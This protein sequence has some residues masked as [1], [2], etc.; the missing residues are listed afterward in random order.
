LLVDSV[1]DYTSSLCFNSL[2]SQL[3][4]YIS[5]MPD[6][7]GGREVLDPLGGY[8]SDGSDYTADATPNFQ[9][10]VKTEAMETVI[11]AN[12]QGFVPGADSEVIK[13]KGKAQLE[14]G[15]Q[16]ASPQPLEKYDLLCHCE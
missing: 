4:D 5:A 10:H 2:S 11:G 12:A 14:D 16:Q 9:A 3:S 6:R 15:D 1:P 13:G 8:W 7:Y